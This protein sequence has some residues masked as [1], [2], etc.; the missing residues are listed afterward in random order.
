MDVTLYRIL[1]IE[2]RAWTP[3]AERRDLQRRTI[4]GDLEIVRAARASPGGHSL[5]RT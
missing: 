2:A 1:D 5:P 4:R 3:Y